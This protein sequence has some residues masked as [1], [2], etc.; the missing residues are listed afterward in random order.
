MKSKLLALIF[1]S[2]ITSCSYHGGVS[3]TKTISRHYTL[4]NGHASLN[5]DD[6]GTDSYI[7]S[8]NEGVIETR[9]YCNFDSFKYYESEE[10]STLSYHI[11]FNDYISVAESNTFFDFHY[12]GECEFRI[13]SITNVVLAEK[14]GNYHFTGEDDI[15]IIFDDNSKSYAKTRFGL[16]NEGIGK[17]R[18]TYLQTPISI[19]IDGE[20]TIVYF[21]FYDSIL[22][23][24]PWGEN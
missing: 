15:S 9:N 11:G 13:T 5:I 23:P 1:I 22:H 14:H 2:F 21:W 19:D 8:K 16:Y 24:S 4:T 6:Y 3:K 17:D 10:S 12:N 7:V 20:N 18:I